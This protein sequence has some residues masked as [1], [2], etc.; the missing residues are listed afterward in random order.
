MKSGGSKRLNTSRTTLNNSILSNNNTF[1]EDFKN[2]TAEEGNI[3]N[4]CTESTD[5]GQVRTNQNH[6]KDR[7]IQADTYEHQKITH[8]KSEQIN[9]N[10]VLPNN[11]LNLTFNRRIVVSNP[12]DICRGHDGIEES[13]ERNITNTHLL[14]VSKFH[15]QYS[16]NLQ[17]KSVVQLVDS[18]KSER[19][20]H[21][22]GHSSVTNTSHNI[23]QFKGSIMQRR[24]YTAFIPLWTGDH[25]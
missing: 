25:V 15:G 19:M 2:I 3:N 20:L 13:K 9:S 23:N 4:T 24:K 18:S 10:Q 16:P 22:A 8:R 17:L 11:S 1:K 7:L 21:S 12:Q 5:V 14:P 6:E